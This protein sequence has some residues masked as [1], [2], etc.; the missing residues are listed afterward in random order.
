MKSKTVKL[1]AYGAISI[2]S[3]VALVSCGGNKDTDGNQT[4]NT[5]QTTNFKPGENIS[6]LNDNSHIITDGDY[7]N[8]SSIPT[9]KA[10]GYDDVA[11]VEAS[12]IPTLINSISYANFAYSINK[13]VATV[14]KSDN[15]NSYIKF[16]ADKN[17]VSYKNLRVFNATDREATYGVDYCLT[18]GVTIRSS[19]KTKIGTAGKDE[20]KIDLNQYNIKIFNENG[21]VYAPYD[22]INV[23]LQPSSMIPY[24]FNGKDFCKDPMS[25]DNPTITSLCYSSAG[26]FI[27]GYKANG[28]RN[29]LMF[30]KVNTRNGEK[31]SFESLEGETQSPR[32]LALYANGTGKL[33]ELK[34]NKEHV[35]TSNQVLRVK[36]TESTDFLTLYVKY[37]DNGTD[38]QPSESFYDYMLMVNLKETRYGKMT[39]SQVL[40]DY[41][42]NLLCLSFDNVY[43][44]KEA[45]KIT[46]FD[47]Y[48]NSI[49][50]L[51]DRLKSTNIATYE[52][53]MY[54]FLMTKIDDGHT[55]MDT[56]SV[57]SNQANYTFG[58]YGEKYKSTHT[59]TILNKAQ[60]YYSDRFPQKVHSAS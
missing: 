3:V 19:N 23:I 33:I 22:L 12:N 52:E 9:Y 1:I 29:N 37:F 36:Y 4:T 15:A 7:S 18:G 50:G 55:S 40:A 21:K 35:D 20:G 30:K 26:S 2:I 59:S 31:Y 5:S 46:S 58:V 34:T 17:E 32:G 27:F 45:K 11:Y 57:F 13:N 56:L 54:E 53:A 25:Y 47:S 41:T 49:S 16:D 24:V 10:K 14:C 8:T 43:A 42:Y 44:N 48:I 39:R 51:K 38:M 28:Y 6:L 60:Q